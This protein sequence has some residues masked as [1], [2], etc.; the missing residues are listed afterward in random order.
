MATRTKRGHWRCFPQFSQELLLDL[1]KEL[2]VPDLFN[3]FS[4]CRTLREVENQPLPI[5]AGKALRTLSVA[6]T[7]RKAYRL[8]KTLRSAEPRPASI[9]T[10]V[11]PKYPRGIF[12]IAGPTPFAVHA[13]SELLGFPYLAARRGSQNP[14]SLQSNKFPA[15]VHLRFAQC[16]AYSEAVYPLPTVRGHDKLNLIHFWTGHITAEETIELDQGYVYQHAD[17]ISQM[18]V[19]SSG[20]KAFSFITSV[21]EMWRVS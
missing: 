14:R 10:V 11:D 5:P 3:L 8:M 16:I 6:G 7:A 15:I 12:C 17:P 1:A 20:T 9:R 18:A 2:D 19:G 21:S 13:D 4:V